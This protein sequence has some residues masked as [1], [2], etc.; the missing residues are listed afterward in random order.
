ML[1]QQHEVLNLAQ[2]GCGQYKIWL[3][4]QSCMS[5]I[6]QFDSIVIS[7]TSP[8]RIYVKEHPIHRDDK[9]HRASDLIYNDIVDKVDLHKDMAHIVLWFEKYFDLDHARF[10]HNLICEKI[11]RTLRPYR[12]KVLHITNIDWS[13][14]YRFDDMISFEFL[15]KTHRGLMNHYSEKGNELIFNMINERLGRRAVD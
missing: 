12:H 10:V 3:Q 8:Y 9:L 4:L 2:A 11:D 14:L 15:F 1:A 13:G 7:H 5:M 6:D